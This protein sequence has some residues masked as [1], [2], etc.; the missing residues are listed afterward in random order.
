VQI[1]FGSE[2][3]IHH[4]NNNRSP[5]VVQAPKTVARRMSQPTASPA[6][7]QLS[8]VCTGKLIMEKFE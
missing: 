1:K 2:N 5:T 8:T 3:N 4:L 6:V 7:Q